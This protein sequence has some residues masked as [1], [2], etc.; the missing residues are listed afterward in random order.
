MRRLV[1]AAAAATVLL[2][3]LAGPVLAAAPPAPPP[4]SADVTVTVDHPAL[5]APT[6]TVSG[7][8][9]VP[10]PLYQIT[11]VHIDVTRPNG[12]PAGPPCDDDG[13]RAKL[14]NDSTDFSYK[15][16][17]LSYNGPYQV[18]VTVQTQLVTDALT[19]S[20]TFVPTSKTAS[21]KVEVKPAPPADVKAVVNP[22]RT[23]TVSWSRNSE[24]DLVGYRVQRRNVG[25]PTFAI[26]SPIVPQPPDGTTVQFTDPGTATTGGAFEYVVVAIRPDGDGALTD[27]ATTPSAG[28]VAVSVG[29]PVGPGPGAGKSP[30][31]TA[32]GGAAKGAPGLPKASVP[33]STELDNGYAPTLPF[34]ARSGKAAGAGGNTDAV[35]IGETGGGSDRRALLLPIAAGLFLCM[36]AA[37]LRWFN[38]RATEAGPMPYLPLAGHDLAEEK[39]DDATSPASPG[40]GGRLYD[41]AD[42]WEAED[43]PAPARSPGAGTDDTDDDW[44]PPVLAPGPSRTSYR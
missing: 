23:V 11:G 22:D 43:H 9:T 6:A 19:N 36:A 4:G 41:Y 35:A 34:P 16:P 15:T 18:T 39:A 7:S 27:R 10:N 21:F 24:P 8:A 20:G 42:L 37:H 2:W 14:G 1:A 40:G 29:A 26:V 17:I 3:P 13:C 44:R 32:G 12:A 25:A 31:G 5:D 38:R 30:V 28:P 33:P